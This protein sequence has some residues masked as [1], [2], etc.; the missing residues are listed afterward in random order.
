MGRRKKIRTAEEIA[1]RKRILAECSV[2]WRAEN[3]EKY[4]DLNRRQNQKAADK[5]KAAIPTMTPEEIESIRKK[6]REYTRKYRSKNPVLHVEKARS[7]RK[8]NPEKSRS[9]TRKWANANKNKISAADRARNQKKET[10]EKRNA[11]RRALQSTDL[12]FALKNRL[13]NR[14]AAA[15]RAF[16]FRKGSKTAD[17]L[18]ADWKTVKTHIE[19]R[20]SAGMTWENRSLWHIDHIIPIASATDEGHLIRLCHYSN[21]QPL[22]IEENMQ[23]RDRLDYIRKSA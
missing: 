4:K 1:E 23:K 11:L 18:G 7:Y 3:P 9:C 2:K 8:L 22:W 13:R 14:T 19:G 20:F 5:M 16:G 17:L 12:M 15:F 10:K 6:Q 21:L